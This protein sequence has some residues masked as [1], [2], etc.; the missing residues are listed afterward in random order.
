MY[1]IL[2]VR[3]FLKFAFE[4]YFPTMIQAAVKTEN[5][6]GEKLQRNMGQSGKTFKKIYNL[7]SNP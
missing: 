4:K 6:H 3:Y 1:A 7:M 2:F 5:E